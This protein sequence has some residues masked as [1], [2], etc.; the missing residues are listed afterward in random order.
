MRRSEPGGSRGCAVAGRCP[1]LQ[2]DDGG[3]DTRRVLEARREAQPGGLDRVAVD[4]PG[5]GGDDDDE[6]R[7]ARRREIARRSRS[8]P[9]SNPSPDRR[10]RRSTAC[11][12]RRRRTTAAIGT[13]TSASAMTHHRRWTTKIA[14]RR[15]VSPVSHRLVLRRLMGECDSARIVG[16]RVGIRTGEATVGSKKELAELLADVGLFSRCSARQRRTIARHAQI[17]ELPAGCRPDPR[18]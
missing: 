5:S 4:R 15:T 8:R 3:H 1:R 17:A 7:L 11:R 18:G 10:N 13:A 16:G 9:G 2:Y 12:A 14:R 6:V